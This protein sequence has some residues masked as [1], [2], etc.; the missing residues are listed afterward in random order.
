[1]IQNVAVV[2]HGIYE[3][4]ELIFGVCATIILLCSVSIVS[5]Y[6][7]EATLGIPQLGIYL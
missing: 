4:L 3:T 7:G 5:S 1:M 2:G 6:I